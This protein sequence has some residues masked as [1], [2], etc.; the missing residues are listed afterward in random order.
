MKIKR[1]ET[2]KKD[3][4]KLDTQNKRV[5]K[6]IVKKILKSPSRFKP[7]KHHSN[8]FRMRFTKLRLIY[9]VEADTIT[10]MFVRKRSE[11]YKNV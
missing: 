3:M 10:F 2:F 8:I 9:K 6:K 5:L 1:T 4:K 11:S 7:L